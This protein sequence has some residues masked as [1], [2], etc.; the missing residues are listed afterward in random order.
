[1]AKKRRRTPLE[2]LDAQTAKIE[3]LE[4]QR[5]RYQKLA[6]KGNA[7]AALA[8]IRIGILIAQIVTTLRV[9]KRAKAK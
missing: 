5:D 8:V 4:R 2:V 1:M 6:D 3:A 7:A 9:R